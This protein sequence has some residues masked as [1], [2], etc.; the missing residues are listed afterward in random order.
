MK[1][2][3]VCHLFKLFDCY[4]GFLLF[5]LDFLQFLIY[6]L[7]LV[8]MFFFEKVLFCLLN[9]E[10]NIIMTILLWFL[11]NK[12]ILFFHQDCFTYCTIIHKRK[13]KKL[14]FFAMLSLGLS[15]ARKSKF[16]HSFQDAIN[17]LYSCRHDEVSTE[18]FLLHY[19][20]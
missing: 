4:P 15:C 8:F 3:L 12:L 20:W 7:N 9:H 17:L 14:V 6:W 10:R 5:S 18:Y 19:P 16:K 2:C 11:W 1:Y 13:I